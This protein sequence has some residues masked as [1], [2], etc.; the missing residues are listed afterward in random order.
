MNPG[1][2]RRFLVPRRWMVE[3]RCRLPEKLAKELDRA[4]AKEGVSRNQLIIDVLDE[5]VHDRD[6]AWGQVKKRLR[7]LLD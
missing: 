5:Y 3:F 6:A 7:D 1:T 4:A 2:R